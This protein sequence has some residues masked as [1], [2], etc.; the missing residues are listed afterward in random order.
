MGVDVKTGQ[1]LWRQRGLAKAQIVFADDK[2]LMV[3]EDGHLALA[4]VTPEGLD[5]LSK[6]E[7]LESRAWT[8]PTLVGTRL[9]VR[10]RK[11]MM[12]LDLAAQGSGF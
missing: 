8:A 5:V 6:V 2:F 7:L 1:V 12:A 11:S 4:R 10:D 9:Y 3:D